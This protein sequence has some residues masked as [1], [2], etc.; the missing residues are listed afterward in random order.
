MEFN[1]EVNCETCKHGYFAGIS[2]D[3]W[4]NLCGAGNCYL[5]ARNYGCCDD[6]EKGEP[7]KDKASMY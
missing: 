5:C 3:G 4:H 6:Y 2:G 1:E 7:P